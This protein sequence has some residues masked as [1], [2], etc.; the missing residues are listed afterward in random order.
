[1]F[2]VEEE[3][4]TTKVPI[5]SPNDVI[6]VEVSPSVRAQASSWLK[7]FDLRSRKTKVQPPLELAKEKKGKR[8]KN[9]T[10][11]KPKE[12][13]KRGDP[14]LP[15][16]MTDEN[17][18]VDISS[19]KGVHKKPLDC[20]CKGMGF[21]CSPSAV[22]PE[23]M[24]QQ[25]GYGMFGKT[26]QVGTNCMDSTEM[27]INRP[28]V[29]NGHNFE[30]LTTK[31]F[32]GK[33]IYGT[34]TGHGKIN[35]PR[36]NS[37]G[38][39][40]SYCYECKNETCSCSAPKLKQEPYPLSDGNDRKRQKLTNKNNGHKIK[41]SKTQIL[42]GSKNNLHTMK[43]IACINSK[44]NTN[45][46]STSNFN[47]NNH[48]SSS[49]SSFRHDLENENPCYKGGIGITNS[50]RSTSTQGHGIDCSYMRSKM[51]LQNSPSMGPDDSDMIPCYR[52]RHRMKATR[53][54]F[55]NLRQPPSL[56]SRESSNG[57]I[58]FYEP[59]NSL[60]RVTTPN[61][62]TGS[63]MCSCGRCKRKALLLS[64]MEALGFPSSSAQYNQS[65]YPYPVTHRYFASSLQSSLPPS[66]R[67]ASCTAMSHSYAGNGGIY[68]PPNS[69]DR[70]SP[71]FDSDS[72]I[73][74]SDI[75][76]S[77]SS[78]PFISRGVN[79]DTTFYVDSEPSVESPVSF[80]GIIED[81][82]DLSI[83]DTVE[84]FMTLRSPL[85]DSQKS[86]LSDETSPD[87]LP[88]L[89]SE[90]ETFSCCMGSCACSL[91]DSQHSI[92]HR[93]NPEM[94]SLDKLPSTPPHALRIHNYLDSCP[95][96]AP[97]KSMSM[98][99]SS[100]MSN[101]GLEDELRCAIENIPME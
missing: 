41:G 12:T 79:T 2:D 77:N 11:K 1:M 66:H 62:I 73:N 48:S 78:I 43:T 81:I 13:M 56:A 74:K 21:N 55:I 98:L 51:Y 50:C 7:G 19:K 28:I 18:V 52:Y 53:R 68:C 15:S 20:K 46:I 88:G 5:V 86:T 72:Y 93:N 101:L 42:I 40:P 47:K 82:T 96:D 27:N 26:M 29:S 17:P 30:N 32:P 67:Y 22:L 85:A 60:P 65:P 64:K 9:T 76:F 75:M 100:L 49:F 97:T 71:I 58:R 14:F 23:E 80:S 4:V 39:T 87:M 45:I 61:Y 25:W 10:L 16:V 54:S 33:C 38:C 89:S 70:P 99:Y 84:F 34:S 31:T 57:N 92:V 94:M 95:S 35:S 8:L 90:D 6:D 44:E 59:H 37:G 69:Y 83:K 36:F 63:Q 91:R 3:D 24:R